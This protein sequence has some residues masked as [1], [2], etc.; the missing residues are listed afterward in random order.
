M[1]IP[2]CRAA[3]HRVT[4]ILRLSLDDT[5]DLLCDNPRLQVIHLLRDS[6]GTIS[7][8]I[9][10][11]WF[12]FSDKSR[13]AVKNNADA[14]CSRMLHD[15]KA[16]TRL[17]RQFPNRAK[18]IH[19]ED[20]NNTIELAKYLY[21]FLGIEF[22]DKYRQLAKTS[23]TGSATRKTNGYHQFSYRDTLTWETVQIVDTVCEHL[24]NESGY[25]PF[26]TEQDLRNI[27]VSAV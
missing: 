12:P 14:M 11:R 1:L 17:M 21:D 2:L 19:Y 5:E 20:F 23:Y 15:I 8:D 9:G 26:A 6:R 24:Y 16:R 27:N 3:K 4:K 10:T 22:S 18:I 7:S 13:E 25:K